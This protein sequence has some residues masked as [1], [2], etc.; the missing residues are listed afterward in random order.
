MRLPIEKTVLKIP[1]PILDCLQSIVSSRTTSS[2]II[3]RANIALLSTTNITN[4]AISK[5]VG[6]HYNSVGR[7]R[8]RLINEIIP[9]LIIISQ[10]NS[11]DL[12][13][14]VIGLLSD[15]YRSGAPLKY[16]HDVRNKIKTIACQKPADYGLD[17]PHWT[18]ELLR[19]VA[20]KENIVDNISVSEIRYILDSAD[21]K[22]WFQNYYCN[23][24][25]KYEDPET[26]SKKNDDINSLYK[27]AADQNLNS[28]KVIHI[29][30]VDEK[31]GIQAKERAAPDLQT[32]PGKRRLVESNYVRHGTQDL[33]GG[34]NVS[35]GKMDVYM[36]SGTHTEMDF[37]KFSEKLI[38]LHPGEEC[39]IIL[40]NLVTHKSEGLVK[41]VAKKMGYEEDLG[42]KGKFG[43]LKNVKS[44]EAFLTD[45][46]HLIQFHYTP[47]HCSWMNQIEIRFSN[48]S[49][50]LLKNNIFF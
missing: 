19:Q 3:Q 41:L 15:K 1:E 2:C 23:S 46:S 45:A 8:Q 49:R 6:I 27:K 11:K 20:I 40:D 14:S 42:I 12:K 24:K 16:G 47:K 38:N 18:C 21:I 39:H 32:Q 26:Y 34:L 50:R 29:Y 44:R 30:S 48:L 31:T 7:W 5:I 9:T 22:P 4:Q 28:G 33:I 13:E 25:E 37:V 35:T 36:F 10:K 43:I 17:V